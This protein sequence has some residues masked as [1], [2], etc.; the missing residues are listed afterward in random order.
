M[1]STPIQHNPT[2]AFTSS[3]SYSSKSD[4][5]EKDKST[6][7]VHKPIV[8]FLNRLKSNNKWNAHMESNQVKINVPLLNA[9]L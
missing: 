8:S 2:Q 1:P 3:S 5:Y 7:Q 9:I 6:D 4:K